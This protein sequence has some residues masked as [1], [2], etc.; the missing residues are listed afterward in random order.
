M[1]SLPTPL[2]VVLCGRTPSI[3]KTVATHL[4]PEYEVIHFIQTI[5]TAKADIP[6]L[7]SGQSPQIPTPNI[8]TT[9]TLDY[10]QPPRAVIFGRGYEPYE[11]EDVRRACAG[12]SAQPVAWVLGDPAQAPPGWPGPGYAAQVAEKVKGVLDG[13]RAGGG[14]TEEVFMY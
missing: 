8:T 4:L 9:A 5:E 10:S 2:R 7:L 13:W 14:R 3:G 6:R 12:R 1:P 11:V